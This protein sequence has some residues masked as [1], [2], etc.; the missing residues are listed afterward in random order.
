MN[1]GVQRVRQTE[2]R[3]KWWMLCGDTT[4]SGTWSDEPFGEIARR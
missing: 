2:S 1:V 3:L 4:Y